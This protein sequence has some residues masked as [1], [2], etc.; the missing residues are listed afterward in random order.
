MFMLDPISDRFHHPD[1]ALYVVR[2][3][4]TGLTELIDTPDFKSSPEWWSP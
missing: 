3:D 4:G 1:N 2:S